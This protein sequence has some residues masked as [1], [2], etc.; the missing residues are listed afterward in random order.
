MH[1]TGSGDMR[2]SGGCFFT[3]NPPVTLV[4]V[5][6]IMAADMAVMFS[7]DLRTVDVMWWF[8]GWVMIWVVPTL[9]TFACARLVTLCSFSADGVTAG[10]LCNP[11][12]IV[13]ALAATMI[14]TASL[15]DAFG[16]YFYDRDEADVDQSLRLALDITLTTL[17]FLYV[18]L[19]ARL[20]PALSGHRLE[21]LLFYRPRITFG[22]LAGVVCFLSAGFLLFGGG[23]VM[24]SPARGMTL[25]MVI[26]GC[27]LLYLG[28]LALVPYAWKRMKD[29]GRVG[30]L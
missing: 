19:L 2:G 24:T 3:F 25:N 26:T 30:A 9:S 11:K 6:A 4:A 17:I 18:G 16:G 20:F 14:V 29:G 23:V 7:F 15:L 10:I 21:G 28:L 22:V 12:V 13:L 27:I 5:V 1:M 8:I